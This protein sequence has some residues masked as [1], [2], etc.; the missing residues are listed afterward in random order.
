[1]SEA[2]DL[3]EAFTRAFNDRE[4][5]RAPEILSPDVE[6]TNPSA[7]T[8]VG[9]EP[10]L[11]FVKAFVVALPD[12]QLRV[13][14]VT[15]SGGRVVCEGHY[16]GTHTGPLMTPQGEVPPTGRTLDLPYADVFET[17]AG[18]IAR[19]RTYYDQTTMAQQ[20]GLVPEPSAA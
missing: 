13:A 3:V 8:V 20:L 19:H 5:S 18:R 6:T 12:S 17:E 11:E 4:W 15:E 10:F 14:T 16:A 9:I 1:M 7:G 2:T